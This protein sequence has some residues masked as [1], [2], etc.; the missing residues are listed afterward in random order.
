MGVRRPTGAFFWRF[1]PGADT[2]GLVEP[3]Y[4]PLPW[5]NRSIPKRSSASVTLL[6]KARQTIYRY[7]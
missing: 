7:H 5:L 1:Y 4:C 6:R 2:R 3:I